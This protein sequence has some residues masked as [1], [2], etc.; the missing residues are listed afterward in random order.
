M[1]MIVVNRAG[2]LQGIKDL[3]LFP[4]P[5]SW[6]RTGLGLVAELGLLWNAEPDPYMIRGHPL[7]G[8]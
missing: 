5:R 2:P 4:I 1:S 6:S 3:L 8:K 7:L